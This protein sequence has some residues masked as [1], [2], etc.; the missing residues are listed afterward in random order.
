MKLLYVLLAVVFFASCA[1]KK[2]T[3]S[4]SQKSNQKS[5]VN[6]G[7]QPKPNNLINLGPQIFRTAIQSGQFVTTA[8]G[9]EMVYTVVTGTPAKLIGFGTGEGNLLVDLVLPGVEVAWSVAVATDGMLYI[10]GGHT[11]KVFKHIPGSQLVED[12][13]KALPS[14]SYVWEVVAGKDGEIFGCTYPGGRVFRFHPDVGFSDIG[15]GPIVDGQ[16]YVRSLAYSP[17]KD[18]IYAAIGSSVANLVELDPRTGAKKEILPSKYKKTGFVYPLVLVPDILGED[19]LFA[20]VAGRTLIY[21][22]KSSEVVEAEIQGTSSR[23]FIN[24]RTNDGQVYYSQGSSSLRMLD[25]ANTPLTPVPMQGR[26]AKALAMSL[27]DKGML[28]ILNERGELIKTTPHTSKYEAIELP[29]PPQPTQIRI[30]SRGADGKIHTSGFPGG[31]NGVYDPKLGTSTSNP[32]LG[33]SESILIDG[34]DM[35]FNIYPGAHVYKYD[36]QKTW[37]TGTNPK[38][39]FT[40]PAQDRIFGAVAVPDHNSL[41]FGTVAKYGV[42]GGVLAKYDKVRDTLFNYGTVSADRSIITLMYEKGLVYGGTSVYGGIGVSPTQTEG[43]LFVWDVAEERKILEIVP[44]KGKKQI[45]NLIMGPDGNIWGVA[46]DTLFIY[47]TVSNQVLNT[48]SLVDY[49]RGAKWKNIELIIHPNGMV[50]GCGTNKSA[51]FSINP[52]TMEIKKI[53]DDA[54]WLSMDDE[55]RFY[56]SRND[57]LWQYTP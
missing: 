32:G 49:Y 31:G 5:L 42:L 57:D 18:K 37:K 38:R 52:T 8:E 26:S 4:A 48:Y 21:N 3:P 6:S 9:V 43:T 56:F 23:A 36:S 28:Y 54:A 15:Q 50:Y 29:I 20:T 40:I 33:Q 45:S 10:A 2:E 17:S 14:E 51:I 1:S 46:E 39:M 19:R 24:S 35:Y 13:G 41:F 7:E 11:G 53:L 55:G 12:L 34:E 16:M 44:V 25:F 22:L 30:T 27:D 47:S